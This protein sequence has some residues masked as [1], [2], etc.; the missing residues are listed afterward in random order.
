MRGSI[1]DNL[2]RIQDRITN[3]MARAG[4]SG[5]PPT[6]V[7]VTKSVGLSEIGE[8]RRLGVTHF[9]ENRVKPAETK[10][11][12]C[13]PGV[14]WH[15]IGTVQ[16]RKAKD[17]VRIF[18]F[19]DA[20]DRVELAAE[21]AVRAAERRIVLPVLLEVNVSGEESKHGFTPAELSSALD[22][23]RTFDSLKVEGLM[24]MAPLHDDVER[25]RPVFAGLCALANRLGLRRV[26][27]GMSNDFEVAIEEGSTEVRIGTAL[28]E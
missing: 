13:G 21:L 3:A 8:L 23:V 17:V 2:R 9:G 20:V 28:F 25:T 18:D 19:V 22:Q 27:M 24:T 12:G 4:R 6:L 11:D 16:R 14:S 26:S 1:A 7:A 5:E 10:I 15:M